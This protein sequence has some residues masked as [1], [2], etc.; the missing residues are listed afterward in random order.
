MISKTK[1]ILYMCVCLVASA[2]QM[3][4]A[5]DSAPMLLTDMQASRITVSSENNVNGEGR[6]QAF[7]SNVNTKWLTFNY[8]GWIAYQFR[9]PVI[10]GTYSLT[11]ANDVPGRDPVAWQLEASNDSVNWNSV[12]SKNSEQFAQR[13]FTK[14][15]TVNSATTA[16]R[17]YRLNVTK[18]N[19]EPI[20]QL[21]E[22]ALTGKYVFGANADVTQPV[23]TKITASAENSAVGEGRVQ[24]FDNNAATKW[25]TFNSTGWIAYQ[26]DKPTSIGAY[27][28]TSA[29]DFSD[30]DPRNW[31]LQ[32]SN[33]GTTWATV[34]SRSNQ[35]FATRF[36]TNTYVFT[37]D[38]T[39]TQYRLSVTANSGANIL[40]LAEIELIENPQSSSASS[41]KS[42]SSSSSIAS[43]KSSSLTW[44]KS[45]SSV[46]S[47]W[48][49]VTSPAV[50]YHNDGGA[51]AQLFRS[52]V[53]DSTVKN[54][55]HQIALDVVKT[56][57]KSPSEV[58]AFSTLELHIENWNDDPGGV[59]WKAGNPPHIT[60]NVNGFYLENISKNGVN[61]ADEVSGVLHHE[62]TH[63]Y[64]HSE[65][66]DLSAV[67][68]TAD[69]VRFLTGYIPVTNRRAGGHWDDSY[70]TTGFFLA[71]IQQ[72]KGFTNFI[73]DFNQQGK[74]GTPG[75]WSWDGAIMNTTGF[76]VQTLWDEYQTW[77]KNGAK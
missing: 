26:F 35:K 51:G 66:M 62:M 24:A 13:F 49:A 59:A 11:S 60:V 23:A 75:T 33:N 64:Q 30:R 27:T 19:G 61:V 39:Y 31:I 10:V 47:D 74:P 9:W 70:Q 67:E 65:G 16:Y 34:D 40:Q 72:Y 25:L 68:G 22:L 56:L 73:H 57:Y 77:L 76:H 46:A 36:T 54:Y 2:A 29:N 38:T 69:A 48:T 37:N 50:D 44:S 17:F 58:P 42:S 12:D 20:L 45:S 4:S 52:L 43:S 63:A 41:S 53:P 3:A 5:A 14:Q 71:W 6:V 28:I 1:N 55:V 21:A 8:T 7:D 15:Y 18:N 32:G